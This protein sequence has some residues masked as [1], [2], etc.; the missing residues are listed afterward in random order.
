MHE[1]EYGFG[2]ALEGRAIINKHILDGNHAALKNYQ[3]MGKSVS[4]AVPSP[5]HY[6]PLMYTLS[7]KRD[8]EQVSLFNDKAVMGSIS[9]TSVLIG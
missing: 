8:H 6:L 1:P 5:D 3:Q 2:W 7:L 9:M 4:L